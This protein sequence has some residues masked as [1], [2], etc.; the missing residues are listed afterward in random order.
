MN[1]VD[2]TALAAL[3]LKL[4]RVRIL[5]LLAFAVAAG[6][7]AWGLF[8]RDLP[9][10]E[11]RMWQ[12]RDAQHRVRAMFGVSEGG[13]GLTMYDTSGQIRLDV[14]LAP[15]G[16]P[17]LVLLSSSGGAVA[18][19]NLTRDGVPSLRLANPGDQTRIQ[20]SPAAG[21]SPI[22][23]IDATGSDSMK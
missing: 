7:L 10:A 3:E 2:R 5:A 8:E 14:G 21:A 16:G 20:L 15:N 19:L 17:G 23:R 13:V 9:I 18:T 1:D 6:A 11:A 4:K 22:T 12:V